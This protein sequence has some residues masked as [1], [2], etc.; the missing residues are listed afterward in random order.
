MDAWDFPRIAIILA[1]AFVG[2]AL[3]AAIMG[4]GMRMRMMT[5]RTTLVV[6]A[7]GAPLI[8]AAI[9][10]IYFTRFSFTSPLQ[11]AF[12]FYRKWAMQPLGFSQGLHGQT[13]CQVRIYQAE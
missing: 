7:V 6:H 1:H 2:W 10:A 4:V 8:F 11:T 5:L 13:P 9:S 12:L 3:C